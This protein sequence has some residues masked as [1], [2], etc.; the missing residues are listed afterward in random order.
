M[1]VY[2]Q[3]D[4]LLKQVKSIPKSAL[5]EHKEKEHIV[6]AAGEAT[7]HAHTIASMA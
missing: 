5:A 2:R 7:G 6:L 3:G 1:L 4:V